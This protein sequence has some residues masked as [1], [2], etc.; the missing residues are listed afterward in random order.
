MIV[1]FMARTHQLLERHHR[2]VLLIALAPLWVGMHHVKD[3]L[4][5]ERMHR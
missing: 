3:V 5:M 1:L 4:F 2:W